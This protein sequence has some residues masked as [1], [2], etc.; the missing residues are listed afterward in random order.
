M[1]GSKVVVFGGSGFLGSHVADELSESGY[2]VRIFDR[3]VSPFLRESQEMVVGDIMD[4][5][6]VVR[7]VEGCE[8]VYNFAGIADI[9]EAKDRPL[10]TANTNIIGNLHALEGARLAGAKR[11]V[12]ASTV[13]VYSEAGSF[14]RAS[15]QASERFVEAYHERYGLPFSVL[16]YGSLY[17]RRADRRNGIYRMLRQALE[18]RSINYVGSAEAMREYIHVRDAARLSVQILVDEYANR[19]LILS[20]QERLSVRNL[21]RMI[22]EMIPG[23]VELSFG[24]KQDEGHYV[25]TPY[26]FHPKVGHKLVAN[27]Y[28][29]LGQGLLDCLAELHEHNMPGTHPEGDWLVADHASRV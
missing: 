19:H 6:A 23:G 5:E 3:I 25:M 24:N 7:A 18:Q 26:A 2:A 17:G 21:M 9:D 11:F 20:G 12:F 14:Y 16:R 8:Y 10:D 4:R 13:Y 22:S 15:K 27:D 28:V 29:E 1:A